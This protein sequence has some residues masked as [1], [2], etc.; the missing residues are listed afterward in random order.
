MPRLLAVLL[1]LFIVL[2]AGGDSTNRLRNHPSPYL[3]MHGADP[4]HWQ[5]WGREALQLAREENRLLFVSSGYFACHWCHVMQQ[6]SYRDPEVAALLNRHF[7]PV[8]IDRE[9][10]P[11]L[12]AHLVEFVQRT[13]GSAGWPLNVF[14]TPE[15]FPL[16]GLTYASRHDFLEFLKRLEAVWG[17]GSDELKAMARQAAEAIDPPVS[18]APLQEPRVLQQQLVTMALSLGDELEGGFGQQSRFPMAPQWGCC[19]GIWKVVLMMGF[20]TWLP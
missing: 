18:T 15:G 5:L 7:V 14:L 12:D 1:L 20:A 2:P 10:H 19:S 9:L 4:V 3:A 8:K 17:K 11:A 13:R 16:V 6:E